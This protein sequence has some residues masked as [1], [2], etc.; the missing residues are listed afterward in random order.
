[1]AYFSRRNFFGSLVAFTVTPQLGW[2]RPGDRGDRGNGGDRYSLHG[3]PGTRLPNGSNL[4]LQE[5]LERL[6]YNQFR[7]LE[8]LN[9]KQRL[10]VP[11]FSHIMLDWLF[12]ASVFDHKRI[13]R[14]MRRLSGVKDI[15]QRRAILQEE[16]ARV[17]RL[18]EKLE[19]DREPLE[20]K[21]LT[22]E[23]LSE[24]ENNVYFESL[25]RTNRLGPYLET[26]K[27]WVQVPQEGILSS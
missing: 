6:S 25:K 5:T 19:A 27:V 10:I 26:L 9:E 22:D 21:I 11:G 18:I 20:D 23:G 16:V 8:V 12:R 14:V 17:E 3:V 1:M 2:A 24:R 15:E 13:Q 7:W 4:V